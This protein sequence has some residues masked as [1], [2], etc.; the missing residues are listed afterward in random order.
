MAQGIDRVSGKTLGR[1][2][3]S[4]DL[5][6]VSISYTLRRAS[7]IGVSVA[8]LVFGA[9]AVSAALQGEVDPGVDSGPPG[10]R[11]LAVLPGGFA[12]Q[13]GIRPGQVVVA[14]SHSDDPGGWR[15]E[16]SDGI[17]TF[18]T[19]AAPIEQALRYSLP[20]GIAGLAFGALAVLLLG[21]RRA[22]VVPAS[23]LGLAASSIP[24]MLSGSPAVSA[25]AMAGAVFAPGIWIASRIPLARFV[26]LAMAAA[27]VAFLALWTGARLSGSSA[28]E[29][30]EQLR[31]TLVVVSI[32]IVLVARFLPSAVDARPM[33]LTRPP[34]V[35]VAALATLAALGMALVVVQVVSPIWVAAAL[36][37]ALVTVPPFRRR[38]GWRFGRSLLADVRAQA[39]A[40]GAEQERAHLAR[41]LHDVPLQELVGVIRRLEILPGAIGA[42]EDL[43]GVAG[44]LRDL[45]SDLRPPVLDDFGLPAA[46]DYLAEEATTPA[47][48]V[49]AEIVDTTGFG[50][51]ARP[52]AAVELAMYRIAHEAVA[53]AVQHS[54]ATAI[55]VRANVSPD[56][57]R[58]QVIDD[59]VGL[60]SEKVRDATRRKRLGLG[61][62]RRRA[63]AIDAEFAISSSR[64]GTEVTVTW[65]S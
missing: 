59:G 10:G 46:L 4:A 32:L 3:G 2:E 35:D 65:Q 54:G 17:T 56:R 57:V 45:A 60:D 34:L 61:S 53:N 55:T 20:I 52:P 51:G 58:L 28:Y 44:H 50:P 41:E 16:T 18:S 5:R 13:A 29:S 26:G 14:M 6:S 62:M 8:A 48:P 27:L 43:R 9:A 22:W 19:D 36:V 23:S 33:H 47:L 21:T 42:S 7:L 30:L 11:I 40:E 12:W 39:A 15:L 38:Y 24:L 63:Q 1:D 49:V 64:R 31:G 37:L 25:L